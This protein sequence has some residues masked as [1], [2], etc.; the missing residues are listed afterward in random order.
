MSDQRWYD[1][2]EP[3]NGRFLPDMFGFNQNDWKLVYD[4][5][6][7]GKSQTLHTFGLALESLRDHSIIPVLFLNQADVG[8][9]EKIMLHRVKSADVSANLGYVAVDFDLDAKERAL[10]DICNL[11]VVR[12]P[13]SNNRHQEIQ[14]ISSDT[15]EKEHYSIQSFNQEMNQKRPAIKRRNRDRTKITQ[16]ILENVLYLRNASITQLIYKCNLNYKSAKTILNDLIKRDLVKIVNYESNGR[17]YELTDR[18]KRALEKLRV[19]EAV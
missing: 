9:S 2:R 6:V 13:P 8:K 1:E 3:E 15:K 18:G 7:K 4:M 12:V 11:S 5:R 16:E 17:R 14:E 19:Y 10:C